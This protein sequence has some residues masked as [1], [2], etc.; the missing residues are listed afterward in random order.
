MSELKRIIKEQKKIFV[1]FFLI[2]VVI[3]FVFV[4]MW[5]AGMHETSFGIYDGDGSALSKNIVQMLDSTDNLEVTY[6]AESPEDLQEAV[7]YKTVA[8]GIIIPENFN[9]DIKNKLCPT[10]ILMANGTDLI[11]GGNA[12]GSAAKVIGTLNAGT[13]IM[14]LQGGGLMPQTA[15]T[16]MGTFSY[17]ERLMYEPTAG[18]IPK[19]MY[20]I[21]L[22]I[23]LSIFMQKFF[24]PY[25]LQKR[26]T[27]INCKKGELK[28]LNLKGSGWEQA[29]PYLLDSLRYTVM[30]MA[31][32]GF[33]LKKDLQRNRRRYNQIDKPEQL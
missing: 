11:L 12:L 6:F 28:A 30:W 21:P 2:I 4:S 14:T 5:Q 7:K 24:M 27:M 3:P 20:S 13:Q 17:V 31:I 16:A 10:V 32:S 23:I 22:L 29:M 18:I 19:L 1:S 26:K 25:M 15:M 8:A 33:I 9:M